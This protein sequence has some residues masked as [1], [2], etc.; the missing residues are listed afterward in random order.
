MNW[1]DLI[2]SN[3][4]RKA[5]IV[6]VTIAALTYLGT[7]KPEAAD[8]FVKWAII[9]VAWIGTIGIAAQ[10]SIDYKFGRQE[11]SETEQE[12]EQ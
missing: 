2:N 10:W 1:K 7:V 12:N 3:F 8:T 4:S 5:E 9:A 11:Q 6:I